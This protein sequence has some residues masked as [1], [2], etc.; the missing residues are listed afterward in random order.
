MARL[1]VVAASVTG[2]LWEHL[3][4]HLPPARAPRARPEALST[5]PPAKPRLKGFLSWIATPIADYFAHAYHPCY[6]ETRLQ[7][8]CLSAA[9]IAGI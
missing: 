1:H 8:V 2:P 7:E 6:Q 4:Q 5:L 3:A 9:V